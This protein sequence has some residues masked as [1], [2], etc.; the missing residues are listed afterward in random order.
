ETLDCETRGEGDRVLLR[1]GHIEIAIRKTLREFDE[2]RALPHGW[3][4]ADDAWIAF[5]HVAQPAAEDLRVGRPGALLLEDRAA[6]RVE[7]AW[8]VPL[9]RVRFSGRVA[10]ALARDDVQELRPAQLAQVAQRADERP[11]IVTVNRPD[12]VESHLL[13]ER[14]GQHH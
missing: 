7:G 3:R 13:E 8:A 4:D 6:Y 10:F 12:V 5:G 14:P 9:D 11:D 2:A 1:D